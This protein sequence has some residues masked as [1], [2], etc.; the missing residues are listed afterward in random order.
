M[1][2]L[3]SSSSLPHYHSLLIL[4][5][6]ERLASFRWSFS[7]LFSFLFFLFYFTFKCIFC[8]SLFTR[9]LIG[10]RTSYSHVQ[11]I[12]L[13]IFSSMYFLYLVLCFF[14]FNSFLF[15]CIPLNNYLFLLCISSPISALFMF[16]ISQLRYFTF[17]N[18]VFQM[19]VLSTLFWIAQSS[20]DRTWVARLSISENN[21]YLKSSQFKTTL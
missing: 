16:S 1:H 17:S 7:F 8:L 3:Q 20:R 10:N 5:T 4:L 13:F 9:A 14:I 2:R 21:N 12:C 11:T 15:L 18:S 6:F 19:S